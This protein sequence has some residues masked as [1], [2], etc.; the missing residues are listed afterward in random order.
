MRFCVPVWIAF[1]LL[2]WFIPQSRDALLAP[3]ENVFA[4]PLSESNLIA[5]AVLLSFAALGL[6]IEPASFLDFHVARGGSRGTPRV[7]STMLPSKS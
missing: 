3:S 1:T 6:F 7:F 2:L 4:S 5:V